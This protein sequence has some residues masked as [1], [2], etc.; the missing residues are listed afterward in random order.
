MTIY[1]LLKEDH[2]K[3]EK[4]LDQLVNASSDDRDSW[5]KTVERIRDEL[6]PHARAEESV[7]YNSIRE[8]D[9]GNQT[10]R[11]SYSEHL[12]AEADL[13]A[14]LAMK[15]IDV[16]WTALAKKLRDDLLHHV[17]EEESK[18]FSEAR[19]LFDEKE[20][21]EIGKAFQKLKPIVEDQSSI[22]TTI[23]LIAN[24]LPPR[25][26]DSFRNAFSRTGEKKS[27]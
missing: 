14:L 13:R 22:G 19:K 26:V 24:L 8:L 4:L 3:V 21:S 11:H 5:R 17:R 12:M 25:L 27:A 6:I 2:R 20:A 1:E 9:P 23:D 10:V 16:N 7:F 15:V 18:V